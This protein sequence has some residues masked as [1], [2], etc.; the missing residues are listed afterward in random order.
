MDAPGK[1]RVVFRC[2][3][4]EA[5]T[6]FCEVGGVKTKLASPPTNGAFAEVVC[7]LDFAAGVQSVRLFN[8]SSPMPDVDSMEIR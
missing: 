7:E 8:P 5:R 3:S 6:F 4:P 1:R 2:S